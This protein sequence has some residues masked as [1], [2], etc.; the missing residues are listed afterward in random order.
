MMLKSSSCLICVGSTAGPRRSMW[1]STVRLYR[2]GYSVG[3]HFKMRCIP[4]SLSVKEHNHMR[5]L[6][7]H[8][9]K[10]LEFSRNLA[11]LLQLKNVNLLI[12]FFHITF[13]S[14]STIY[15]SALF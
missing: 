8:T 1:K 5:C 3:G 15:I 12:D 11:R 14:R 6:V 7:S 10:F 9:G 4:N 13:M 2:L